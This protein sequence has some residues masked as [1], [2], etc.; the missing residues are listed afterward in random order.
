VRVTE[1]FTSEEFAEH[2]GVEYPFDWIEERLRPLCETLEVV[3]AEALV[4][5]CASS[6][7][8][9]RIN[10]G[11]RSLAYD[12]RLY[13]SYLARIHKGTT[14]GTVAPPTSSQHPKGRAADVQHA[15]LAPHELF[16]LVLELYA[17]GKLPHLGG[18]GLYTAFCHIDVRPR[19]GLH[20]AIWGGTRPSNIL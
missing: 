8:S 2:S 14:T 18:V 10:S 1:H 4:R 16:N 7:G 6:G 15:T 17:E 13:D 3:R 11:Y 9:I 12:Q 19:T 5:G 20:L